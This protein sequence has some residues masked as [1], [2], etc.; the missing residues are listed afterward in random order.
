LQP[1]TGLHD[2]YL[3]FRN[4]QAAAGAPQLFVLTTATFEL[5]T[6]TGSAP[7]PASGAGTTDARSRAQSWMRSDPILPRRAD[8]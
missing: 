6:R 3:V 7:P 1:T 5:G 2:V 4:D 8:R